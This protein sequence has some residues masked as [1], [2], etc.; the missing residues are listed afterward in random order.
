LGIARPTVESYLRALEITNAVT[1]VRPFHGGGQSEIVKTPKV[2]GF[3][4]GFVAFARGW[5]PI[6][7]D[8]LGPLWE[9]F[10]LEHLQALFPDTPV[11]YWRDKAGREVDFVLAANLQEVD[12]VE[13]T[14]SPGSFEPAGLQQFRRAYPKGRNYLVTPSG[15]PA[16]TK[17]IGGFEVRVCTPSNLSPHKGSGAAGAAPL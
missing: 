13:C 16:F 5:D 4:T 1:I 9:H 6:R 15:D 11:R 8:D 17:V 10:V 7:Q 12:A 14:W 3:D 2:Y